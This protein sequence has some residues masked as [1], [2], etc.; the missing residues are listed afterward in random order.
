MEI[1]TRN[2]L[3]LVAVWTSPSGNRVRASNVSSDD[4]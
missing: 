2:L 3:T 4:A 1:T